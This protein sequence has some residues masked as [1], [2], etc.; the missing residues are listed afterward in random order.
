MCQIASVSVLM[1][2]YH[3]NHNENA[4]EKVSYIR[5]KQT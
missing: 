4:N 5:Q 1:R 3:Y 2:F